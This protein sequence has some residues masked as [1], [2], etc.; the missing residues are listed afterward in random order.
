MPA[1][2]LLDEV[3]LS[4]VAVVL[5]SQLHA[6]SR[7]AA[8]DWVSRLADIRVRVTSMAVHLLPAMAAS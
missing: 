8:M 3:Q 2:S 7:T 6:W 5:P 4:N 1:R